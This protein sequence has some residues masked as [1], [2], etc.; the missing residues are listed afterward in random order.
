MKLHLTAHFVFDSESNAQGYPA[1][2]TADWIEKEFKA[3][4]KNFRDIVQTETGGNQG[5]MQIHAQYIEEE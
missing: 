5:V 4:L 2:Q 3:A 1:S